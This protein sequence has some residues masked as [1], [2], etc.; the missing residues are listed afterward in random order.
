[1]GF[2]DNT[3]LQYFFGKLKEYFN[4][5]VIYGAESF[6]EPAYENDTDPSDST[7]TQGYWLRN[8]CPAVNDKIQIYRLGQNSSYYFTDQPKQGVSTNAYLITFYSY[9]D[10]GLFRYYTEIFIYATGTRA[11]VQDDK[12]SAG[13][14]FIRT[15]HIGNGTTTFLVHSKWRQVITDL[16]NDS[17]SINFAD[18]NRVSNLESSVIAANSAISTLQ[19]ATSSIPAIS[20]SVATLEESVAALE[21]VTAPFDKLHASSTK[22]SSTS[23][24]TLSLPTA[25]GGILNCSSPGAAPGLRDTIYFGVNNTGTVNY[26]RL[27]DICGS[28]ALGSRLTVSVDGTNLQVTTSSTGTYVYYIAEY[29]H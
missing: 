26:S 14:I 28:S 12:A 21:S 3:G 23:T 8:I 17:S 4:P 1:M 7:R 19:T 6:G 9:K 15:S 10:G 2:L 25:C 18:T 16:I 29:H 20:S 13:N 5:I 27:S 22:L 11:D 24:Y